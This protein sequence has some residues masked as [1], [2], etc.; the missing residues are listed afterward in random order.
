MV[1]PRRKAD[2]LAV[3][4]QTSRLLAERPPRILHGVGHARLPFVECLPGGLDGAHDAFFE[5]DA[6]LLHDDD[7]LLE[8]V[9]FV[10]LFLELA[11]DGSICYVSEG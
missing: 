5:V 10:V 2:P 6:V 1:A 7:G 4:R 11:G 9:L 8:G 3:R